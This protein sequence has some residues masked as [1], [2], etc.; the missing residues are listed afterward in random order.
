M[1]A[2]AKANRG[3]DALVDVFVDMK[4]EPAR[5]SYRLP[6]APPTFDFS[7]VEH[8][9]CL[10]IEA[11]FIGQPAPANF[12]DFKPDYRPITAWTPDITPG[13]SVW[14]KARRRQNGMCCIPIGS[15]TPEFPASQ[16]CW[17]SDFTCGLLICAGGL[18]SWLFGT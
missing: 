11:Y 10:T 16:P 5:R 18:R 1:G 7:K 4:G 14:I 8:K 3:N 15:L 13:Q 2:G 17:S 12:R 9:L 6:Y